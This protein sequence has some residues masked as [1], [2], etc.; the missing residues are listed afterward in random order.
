[1]GGDRGTVEADNLLYGLAQR[2]RDAQLAGAGPD[3][4][5]PWLFSHDAW[6]AGRESCSGCGWVGGSA[7]NRDNV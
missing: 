3:P 5:V 1:M 7:W 2:E 6:A 4:A